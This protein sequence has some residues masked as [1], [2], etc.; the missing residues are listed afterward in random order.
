M[1]PADAPIVGKKNLA[2]VINQQ[3]E[4]AAGRGIGGTGGGIDGYYDGPGLSETTRH[5][6][7]L[8]RRNLLLIATI[9]AAAI[10]VAVVMTMLQTPMYTATTSVQINNQSEQVL[11]DQLGDQ[12]NQ[13]ASWDTDRFL[14]TQLEI[15][16]SRGLA[17]RV[18][19]RLNLYSDDR[20][21]SAM[22]LPPFNANQTEAQ[23]RM[24]VLNLLRGGFSVNLPRETRIA[25]ISFNSTDPAYS[26]KIANAFAEEF[27]QSNLQRKFDSSAYA[28][29]FVAQQMEEA[30][31]R[32]ENSERDL[33]AYA[34][35]A[36]LIRTRSA[37]GAGANGTSGSSD[38]GT[39]SVTAASL[40]Q[41]NE[42]AN[43]AK[44]AVTA[45][46]AKWK[47][48]SSVPMLASQAVLSNG[49]IQAL[50][51]QKS[52]V[53]TQLQSQR[54]RYL[55]DHPSVKALEAQLASTNA[56]IR[57]VAS[58]I[59]S[60]IRN[61]YVAAQSA[62]GQ[63]RSQV[64]ALQNQTMSE[65]D[66]TVRY[67]TLAREGDTNRQLYDGLLQRYREL[68]AAAGISASN[69]SVIDQA[70]APRSPSS[71]NLMKNI[72]FSIAAGMVLAAIVVFMRDQLDDRIRM[73]EDVEEKVNLPLLGVI[74]KETEDDLATQ[75]AD[76]KSPLS[77]AY[78]SLRGSLM[79]STTQGLPPILLVTSS[80]QSEGKSTTSFATARALSRVGKRVLLIDA[81]MRR[82]S[83][84]SR[85]GLDN[86]A[87][88]STLLTSQQ[89]AMS[90]VRATDEENLW[91]LT[92][93][94]HPPSPS[95]LL[96]SPRMAQ[97]LEELAKEFDSIVIDS[98][99]VLGLADAPVLSAIADGVAFVIEAEGGQRGAV[100]ASLRR[101]RAMN[102][103]IVGAI[104]T[105][106]DPNKSSNRY[107]SYYGYEYY[108]YRSE[109]TA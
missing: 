77:E 48:E 100:K 101:L 47:A 33:N 75:L 89:A 36:G 42:A 104:L 92:S 10:G 39:G 103:V 83:I 55:A 40:S 23:R 4:T 41:I 98:P 37:S 28:R 44:A 64:N 30:R 3:D 58:G 52:Q 69:V 29:K 88:L 25:Q 84:H 9:V 22:D 45:A 50:L 46:E 95:E 2:T 24:L 108:R 60:S 32:L 65:Q 76:P 8:V 70:E 15:L 57:N 51:A 78:S 19:R 43:T 105:K 59:R 97:I 79:Y 72:F 93:G 20:F 82:P 35:Q 62:E 6:L 5:I 61:E 81:D 91:V 94:P 109:E 102:P 74:P 53:E 54:T 99:P 17:E 85:V 38:G 106:F 49:T 31:V 16:R 26:A 90:V 63:L 7:T 27:I 86:A 14:N 13:D 107:S 73:P 66:R 87:G 18:A 96:A 67:N 68:N 21:L 71:P 1:G 34:R 11:G 80:Q 12:Q 56:E